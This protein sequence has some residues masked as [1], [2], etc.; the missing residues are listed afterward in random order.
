M[1]EPKEVLKLNNSSMHCSLSQL[2]ASKGDFEMKFNVKCELRGCWGDRGANS[3][4][5]AVVNQSRYAVR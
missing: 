1:V 3:R 4:K 5:Q 2:P